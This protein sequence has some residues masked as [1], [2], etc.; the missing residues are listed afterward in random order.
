[1]KIHFIEKMKHAEKNCRDFHAVQ[2]RPEKKS[3]INSHK[4]AWVGT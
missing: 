2:V 4:R 3:E 1:M